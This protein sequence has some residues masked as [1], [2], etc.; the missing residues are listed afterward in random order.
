MSTR[1]KPRDIIYKMANVLQFLGD[2]YTLTRVECNP[3]DSAVR[4]IKQNSK[5]TLYI[6]AY[7]NPDATEI[8]VYDKNGSLTTY[9][10]F[11]DRSMDDLSPKEIA[12][13]IIKSLQKGE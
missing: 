4:V 8:H 13:C 1:N 3:G 9:H 10:S 5:K 11:Y 2:D 7:S 6:I 12:D